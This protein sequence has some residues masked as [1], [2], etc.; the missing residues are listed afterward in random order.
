MS[1]DPRLDYYRPAI[2]SPK[3]PIPVRDNPNRRD[4]YRPVVANPQQAERYFKIPANDRGRGRPTLP[5]GGK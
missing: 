2:G 5:G 4:Y 1:D 3:D